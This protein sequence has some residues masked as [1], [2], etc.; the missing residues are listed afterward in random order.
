MKYRVKKVEWEDYTFYIPQRKGLFFWKNYYH[1]NEP[2]WNCGVKI[3][4]NSEE[5]A[6]EYIKNHKPWPIITYTYGE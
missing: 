2:A 1:D 3:F 6:W 5:K 4:F